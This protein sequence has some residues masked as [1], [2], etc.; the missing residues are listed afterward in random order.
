MPRT[1]IAAS[2]F[3][4]RRGPSHCTRLA[5][6]RVRASGTNGPGAGWPA[7]REL[8][9]PDRCL[10]FGLAGEAPEQLGANGAVLGIGAHAIQERGALLFGPGFERIHR[11]HRSGRRLLDARSIT[12]GVSFGTTAS[13]FRFSTTCAGRLAPV[14]TVD[15]CGFLRHH[16]RDIWASVQPSS[17]AIGTS[18]LTL[19]IPRRFEDPLGEPFEALDAPRANPRARRSRTCRSAGPMRAGSTSS[20]R[21]RCRDT[22]AHIPVST[23][24][25]CSRL[26]CG[27]SITG[28][29]R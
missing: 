25:R 11:R 1:F 23:R 10:R 27:C 18:F 15:T 4:S 8:R 14:I 6:R 7:R 21:A 12:S 24:S 2:T 26:Y 19:A 5:T 29:C 20:C 16:A 28:L 9:A 17:C 13:A 22:A 3:L